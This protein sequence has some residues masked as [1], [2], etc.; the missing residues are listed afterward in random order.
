MKISSVSQS[1]T[2][3]SN[4]SVQSNSKITSIAPTLAT[5]DRLL[6]RDK[7][8][9]DPSVIRRPPRRL[10]MNPTHEIMMPLSV[11]G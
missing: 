11:Y 4:I 6:N 9:N 10:I 7:I 1:Q 2:K 3:T 5:A 8:R